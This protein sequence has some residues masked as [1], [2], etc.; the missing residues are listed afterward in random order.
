MAH[1]FFSSFFYFR[2]IPTATYYLAFFS[3][4][5]QFLFF[6]DCVCVFFRVLPLRSARG[7]KRKSFLPLMGREG[8]DAF[9]ALYIRGKRNEPPFS[10]PPPPCVYKLSPPFP[11][12]PSDLQTMDA[13]FLPPSKHKEKVENGDRGK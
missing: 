2:S 10:P 1:V 11:S 8:G 9:F 13:L 12:A 6:L 7:Y 4:L 3:L 5:A